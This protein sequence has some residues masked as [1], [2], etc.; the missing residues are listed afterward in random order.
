MI[1]LF[2]LEYKQYVSCSL[3]FSSSFLIWLIWLRKFSFIGN[4]DRHIKLVM[5]MCKCKLVMH[6]LMCFSWDPL[7]THTNHSTP[8][9][10]HSN[11]SWMRLTHFGEDFVSIEQRSEYRMILNIEEMLNAT[12]SMGYKAVKVENFAKL[13]FVQQLPTVH[14]TDIL[15]GVQGAGLTW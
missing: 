9:T 8:F 13:D 2:G 5:H 7:Y 15:I 1:Q 3:T 4:K 12:R 10:H 14:C 6:I 11:L